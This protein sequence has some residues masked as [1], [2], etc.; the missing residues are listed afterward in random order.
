VLTSLLSRIRPVRSEKASPVPPVL[1]FIIVLIIIGA[2]FSA[3][4]W[5]SGFDLGTVYQA[6]LKGSFGSRDALGQT[7]IRVAPLL[8]C[9]LG[10]VIAFRCGVWNIGSE[11][12]LYIG[13]LISTLIGIYIHLPAVLHVTLAAIASFV[14]S[15][16]W[17][18]VAGFL[19]TRFNA[20]VIITTLLSNFIATWLLYYVLQFHLKPPGTFNVVSDWIQPTAQLPIVV[21]N[22][23]LHAGVVLAI[24]LT[25]VVWF[26]MD[27]TYLGYSI[28]AVG[29]SNPAAAYGGI[30]VNQKI[31]T[32]MF[33][34]GGFAGIAGM[35]EVLG[36]HHL[37][38]PSIS[39]GYGFIAI[40]IALVSKM[41]PI[42]AIPVAIFLGAILAGGRY[43]QATEGVPA[44]AVDILVG[45]FIIFMLLQTVLEKKLS[46]VSF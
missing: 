32:S 15:G 4:I 33:L 39:P 45:L 30:K 1:A 38:R 8:L 27:R 44:P 21:S 11:G 35:G 31:I 36:I 18:A 41:N 10:L 20:N 2:I 16:L 37:L 7:F 22:T 29:V 34:S 26:I 5:L 13:A 28:K 46:R 23:L 9:S 3:L 43:L 24:V 17:A 12:Q 25:F 14:G 19:K 6:L 42:G 40:A